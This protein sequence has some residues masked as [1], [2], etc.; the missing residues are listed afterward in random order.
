MVDR[1]TVLLYTVAASAAAAL[2]EL[3]ALARKGNG[4][5]LDMLQQ[6]GDG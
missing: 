5:P 2:H 4:V 6:V 3:P 1:R